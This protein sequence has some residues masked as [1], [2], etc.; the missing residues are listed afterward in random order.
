MS[1]PARRKL[2]TG[3]YDKAPK[4]LCD[5]VKAEAEVIFKSSSA[6]N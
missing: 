5:L 2:E 4:Y 6:G 3:E 1:C